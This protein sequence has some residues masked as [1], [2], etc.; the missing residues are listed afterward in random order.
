MKSQTIGFL[1]FFFCSL[2]ELLCADELARKA[3]TPRESYSSAEV[4]YDSVTGPKGERLRTIV[5]KPRNAKGRLPV[6]FVAGWLSCD[7]VEAPAGT[8]DATG[9]VFQ[10]LAELPGFC[11]FRLEKA[12]VGDSE[13]DCAGNDFVSE[14]AGYRAGLR[15][16]KKYDFIDNSRIYILGISNGGGYGPLIPETDAERAQVRGYIVVGGW[17]K[18]WFEHMLEIERR[19]FALMGKSP[20][21]INQRMKS[22]AKLYHDWLIARRKVDDVSARAAGAIGVM[23]RRERSRPLVWPAPRVLRTTA[24]PESRRG[25]ESCERA[26][27]NS[28]RAVRLDHE[29]AR[30]RTDCRVR[31]CKSAR[32]RTLSRSPGDGTHFSALPQLD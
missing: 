20:G 11:L 32:G 5:T 12:G 8:K 3:T 22:A 14:L 7:S 1:I 9:L 28:P 19:R 31:E 2:S 29:P 23:A 16:L 6:I 26:N 18:T 21:E 24:R 15:A 30:S 25:L 17:V 4:I 13:G 27:A 10:Q